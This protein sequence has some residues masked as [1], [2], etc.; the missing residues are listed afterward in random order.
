[1]SVEGHGR[2]AA[3][4]ASICAHL[5]LVVAVAVMEWLVQ[6][7]GRSSLVSMDAGEPLGTPTST[8]AGGSD[9]SSAT[10]QPT[11]DGGCAA[12]FTACGRGAA[13]RCYDLSRSVDQC[14]QCG[15]TCAPGIACQS[16]RCQQYACKGAPTFKV[17][18]TVPAA[19]SGSP[20][21]FPSYLPVLGDFDGDGNL[22]FVG[23]PDGD[24]PMGL[25]LGRGDGT[26]EARAL[27]PAFSRAWMAAAAD[28]NGDGRLDLATIDT[29]AEA[30]VTVRLGN[31]D[32][33][34]LFAPATTYP[35][36]S[37]PGSL[38]LAD[39]D[40]DGHVDMVVAETQRLTLWRG[41]ADGQFAAPVDLPVGLPSPPSLPSSVS[42]AYVFFAADWNQD[43]ALDLVYG[44]STLRML[45]GRS[46]G[47]FDKEIACGLALDNFPSLG[48][49]LLAD[50]DHDQ[51]ID[52]IVGTKVFQGMNGCNFSTSV[53]IPIPPGPPEMI[54]DALGVADLNGDSNPDIVAA[55]S[56]STTEEKS[57][58][59]VYLGDGR[60]RF[61][62]PLSFPNGFGFGYNYLLTGD[63]NHDT[64]LDIVVTTSAGWQVLLNTCH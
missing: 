34:T 1:M 54:V 62:P 13:A 39:L 24:V 44:T 29:E 18:P 36:P 49:N 31:G 7:C 51:K 60:G 61:A 58:V 63:L 30:A 11:T 17:L 47:T 25:M 41:G 5:R 15:N 48:F 6:G 40:N 22:D 4:S 53:A 45:L 46:D 33:A 55:Q 12:G 8:T 3:F 9:A 35:T 42:S 16:G 27:A 10:F 38:L 43:G 28:L 19:P 37:P 59:S 23:Q 32:P 56:E 57:Y 52:M 50:F 14:G 64:K 2:L 26:F 20:S 21:S